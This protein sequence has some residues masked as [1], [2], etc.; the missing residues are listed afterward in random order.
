MTTKQEILE[1]EPI[2]SAITDKET[3]EFTDIKEDLMELAVLTDSVLSVIT[4]KETAITGL[5]L[6]KL[7]LER[8]EEKQCQK[9]I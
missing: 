1:T 9:R 3:A 8:I 2:S 6:I 4:N 5:R 7:F